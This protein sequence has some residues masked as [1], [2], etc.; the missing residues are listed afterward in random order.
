MKGHPRLLPLRAEAGG[1]HGVALLTAGMGVINLISAVTPAASERLAVLERFSPLTVAR[2][3]HLA[4]AL[5]GFALLV[6]SLSLWRRKRVAWMLTVMVLLASAIVHLIKGLDYEE[7]LL[8][9]ALVSWLIYLRP[10]FHARSDTPSIRQGLQTLLMAFLF[11]LAYGTSGFYLLDRHFQVNFG[12]WAAVRQTVVMFTQFYDPGLEPITGFGRYFADSIYIIGAATFGYALL[13]LIR[14]V[15]VRH[16]PSPDDMARAGEIVRAYGRTSLARLTLLNDK[17]YFFS[18]GGSVIAYTVQGRVALALGDPIGPTSD[19]AACLALFRH[20]CALNDWQP[21]FYQ[22]L[23]DYLDL[24]KAADFNALCIGHEAI[25]NLADF[26]LEGSQNKNVRNAYNKLVR[27]GY[28]A[29][30]VEPPHPPPLWRELRAISDEWLTRVGGSEMRFSFGWF[31]ENYLNTCPILLVRNPDG[32]IEAFANLILG[33]P[34][35]EVAIDLMRHR[36]QSESGRMEFLFVSL[37]QW[38]KQKGFARLNLGLSALSGVGEK[39]EDPG[40]ER[41]LRY[42]Y[43]HVNRFYN[44]KGLHA[45]KEKFHPLWSPRYLIYPGPASLPAV[46]LALLGADSGGDLLGGYLRHPA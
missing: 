44:F 35:G 19:A 21:A 20:Y 5:A 14:P 17:L 46:A 7:A 16:R 12:L 28:T 34:T 42:L 18:P 4:A 13:M 26:T 3:G 33:F 39:P 23:P 8:S 24:Y 37:I 40:L 29:E 6:L 10:N 22:V 43:Q 30:V 27:L 15:L 45:F 1:V 2:G 36:Q 38:A 9:G 31:D 25:V 32:H 11:T 41:A